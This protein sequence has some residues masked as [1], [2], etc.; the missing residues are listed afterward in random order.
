MG[1][2]GRGVGLPVDADGTTEGRMGDPREEE[3]LLEAIHAEL[4]ALATRGPIALAEAFDQL[5]AVAE[6]AAAGA[7]RRQDTPEWL[8]ALG[9]AEAWRQAGRMVG[10]G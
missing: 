6:D 5:A 8:R 9:R 3:Q 4:G 1:W 10:G 7:L 2:A